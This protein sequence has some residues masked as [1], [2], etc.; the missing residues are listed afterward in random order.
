MKK[1]IIK[2]VAGV[3]LQIFAGIMM[4]VA[5]MFAFSVKT[6]SVENYAPELMEE[7]NVDTFEELA[8]YGHE[9]NN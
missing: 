1:E 4:V 3:T 9:N 5:M 6:D 7:Y 8:N 2:K